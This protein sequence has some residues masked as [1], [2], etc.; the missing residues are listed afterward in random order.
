M[1]LGF[2][3]VFGHDV[4]LAVVPSGA[5]AAYECT[6][7]RI[8]VGREPSF[9]VPGQAMVLSRPRASLRESSR[10]CWTTIGRSDSITLE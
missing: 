2:V 5:T 7:G 6:N 1:S 3:G 8:V 9:Q 10:V 4:L